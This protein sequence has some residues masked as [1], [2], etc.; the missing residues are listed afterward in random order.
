MSGYRVL[1]KIGEGGMSRVYLAERESDGLQLVLK[2]LDTRLAGDP[3]SQAR[4]VREYKIIQRIQNEHVV[5]IFDQGFTA[6]NPW[7][8]MEYFP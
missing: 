1:R 6:G 3:Q 5:M 8:A 2:M 4:F 7:L